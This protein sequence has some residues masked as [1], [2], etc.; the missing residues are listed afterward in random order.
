MV[1]MLP[2]R[3]EA[4]CAVPFLHI[5]SAILKTSQPRAAKPTPQKSMTD[6]TG[7][8]FYFSQ[9]AYALHRSTASNKLL[10]PNPR[11]KGV[12]RHRGHFRST[13]ADETP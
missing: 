10:A 5:R 7:F 4:A 2:H 12:M 13:P 6:T 3:L 11:G 8:P 1:T 9:H